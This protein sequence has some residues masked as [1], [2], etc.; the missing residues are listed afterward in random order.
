MCS[1]CGAPNS[2][3]M[4]RSVSRW[5]PWA[6][7]SMSQPRPAD[8]STLPD[9]QSPWMRLGGSR[10]PASSLIRPVTVS[11]SR[12]SAGPSVPASAARRRYGSTRRS[13]YHAGPAIR[14]RPRGVVQR[15]AGDEP[16]PRSAEAVRAGG[17]HAGRVHGRTSGPR[18]DR[19]GRAV[20]RTAPGHGRPSRG[21]PAPARRRAGQPAQATGFG[22]EG[23]P[24]AGVGDL[25]ERLA[26]VGQG[27]PVV[28]PA[29]LARRPRA[30]PGPRC[31]PARRCAR[32]GPQAGARP[33]SSPVSRTA[34]CRAASSM[35]SSTALKSL[36]SPP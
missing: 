13:A 25:G 4:A 21:R 10:G 2:A 14:G 27:D 1:R 24:G 34:M 31:R 17:V 28:P 33:A 18:R 8:H 32:R 15:Q 7:G 12:T 16:R 19:G 5:P 22:V 30:G 3:S 36:A 6:A 29:V 35:R 23:G 11:T 9:Q 20:S 26:A